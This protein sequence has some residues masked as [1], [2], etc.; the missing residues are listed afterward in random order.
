M[1]EIKNNQID[2]LAKIR[3]N[4]IESPHVTENYK[5]INHD[6]LLEKN[7]EGIN[8]DPYTVKSQKKREE[9]CDKLNNTPQQI[10][11]NYYDIKY[12]NC[13][14]SNPQPKLNKIM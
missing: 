7:V 3:D 11:K 5:Q 12:H 2:N 10:I 6:H 13:I 8:D 4:E 9:T 14:N 1:T